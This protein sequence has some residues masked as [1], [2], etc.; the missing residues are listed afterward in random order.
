MEKYAAGLINNT[1]PGE[2]IEEREEMP[3]EQAV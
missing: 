3:N 1:E 2:E